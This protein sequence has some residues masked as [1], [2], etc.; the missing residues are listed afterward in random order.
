[1]SGNSSPL[2]EA[3]TK[4][5]EGI[6]ELLLEHK[7]DPNICDGKPL[8]E[9]VTQKE[10]DLLDLLLKHKANPNCKDEYGLTPLEHAF[11]DEDEETAVKL[12]DAGAEIPDGHWPFDD[13]NS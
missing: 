6:A 12:R 8:I 13:D 11:G 10:T 9:A 4:A 5:D 3:C 2:V 1:M 7:A